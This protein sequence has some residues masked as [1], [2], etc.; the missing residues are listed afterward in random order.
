MAVSVD[1]QLEKAYDDL[2]SIDNSLSTL[3]GRSLQERLSWE[4]MLRFLFLVMICIRI[5][6]GKIIGLVGNVQHPTTE[7]YL[8]MDLRGT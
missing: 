7:N 1:T 8:T 2:R 5:H 4:L 6:N 3:T